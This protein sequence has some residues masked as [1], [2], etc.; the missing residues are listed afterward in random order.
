MFYSM[1]QEIKMKYSTE[2]KH[3]HVAAWQASG[4][5]KK[6]YCEQTG[7]NHS[8]FKNWHFSS[9]SACLPIKVVPT[10]E[11]TLTHPNG[12]RLSM[13]MAALEQ[14]VHTLLSC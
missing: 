1:R 10:G 8:T 2:Q 4:L 7:I 14:I 3:Q 6:A 12:I 5:T 11:L 9:S 13:P